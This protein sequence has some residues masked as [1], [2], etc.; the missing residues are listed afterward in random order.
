MRTPRVYLDT[1]VI[2]HLDQPKKPIEQEY[3]LRLWDAIIVGEYD[4]W[5]SDV[6]Y[7]ELDRCEPDKRDKLYDF[8]NLIKHDDVPLTDEIKKLADI[9]ISRKILPSSSVNDSRHIISALTAECDF[10]LSWNLRHLANYK[11]NKNIRSIAIEEFKSELAIVQPS[12][13]LEGDL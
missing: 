6:V 1:S 12:F 13:L 10:L 7:E 11:T 5:L 9:V 8:V 2:S 3:S 4:V